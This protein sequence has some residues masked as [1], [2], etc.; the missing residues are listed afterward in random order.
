MGAIPSNI[1][2][3]SGSKSGSRNPAID[4]IDEQLLRK[5]AEETGGR[6]F[7]A[8]DKEGLRNTYAQIDRMEKSEIEVTRFTK[9]E[10]RFLPFVLAALA[11]LFLEII[12]RYT[13]L[14]KFP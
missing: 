2:E 3:L 4:F 14:K 13:L 11:L 12:L 10:E 8:R 9:Y 5:I 1:V 7:R 6:Y